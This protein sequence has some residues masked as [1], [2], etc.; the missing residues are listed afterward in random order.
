MTWMPGPFK[1]CIMR[2]A[3]ASLI[4]LTAGTAQASDFKIGRGINF[5]Q[6]TTWPDR[7][8]WGDPQK[9]VPFPEWR[10]TMTDADLARLKSAGLDFVRMPVDPRIFLAPEAARLRAALLGEVRQAI[11][12]VTGSG[13]K[14]IVDLHAI[15]DGSDLGVRALADDPAAF[16]RYLDLVS[17]MA[18]LVAAE[19]ADTVALGLMNEPLV[20]CDNPGEWPGKLE[21]LHGA[22][23]AAAPET[24]LVLTGGCWGD[25]ESLAALDPALV[26][27]D[28]VL[29]EVHSYAPFVL[30][31]QGAG[32]TGDFVSH[33]V[34]LPYPLDAAPRADVEAA[35]KASKTRFSD[36]LGWSKARAHSAYLDELIAEID[37]AEKLAAA[38]AAPLDI[39]AKW[40]DRH[41]IARDRVLLGEFGMIRQEYEN[42]HIVPAPYRAAYYRDVIGQ[43]EGHGFAWAMWSYGGAFGIVEAFDGARAE[44][45]VLDMVATLPKRREAAAAPVRLFS[46]AGLRPA[47]DPVALR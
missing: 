32:W 30:T 43:A 42:P 44:S 27:D 16:G 31:H 19:P 26:D 1:N 22:A 7:A 14:V 3:A 33:V 24:A 18:R 35:V 29:W 9:V 45:D 36:K 2:L 25:A 15:P 40:A 47:L 28:N 21:R 41:G 10:R 34:G 6:W 23:R 12:F 4:M 46:D 37:T 13:L 17:D 11:R 5:D 38:I 39:A 20:A 8:D